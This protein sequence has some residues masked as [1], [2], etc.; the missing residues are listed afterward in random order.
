MAGVLPG[1]GSVQASKLDWAV[2]DKSK[3]PVGDD[4]LKSDRS[5]NLWAWLGSCSCRQW[6]RAGLLHA[7][8]RSPGRCGVG[9]PGLDCF[10]GP[11]IILVH[12][13]AHLLA[14]GRCCQRTARG[15]GHSGTCQTRAKPSNR[16]CERLPR[17]E[18]LDLARK[19]C[20]M[21]LLHRS[22]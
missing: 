17:L 18:L 6:S 5:G 22:P 12:G 19:A 20:S 9:G 11:R 2:I 15:Q 21:L 8:L 4:A 1:G 10:S 16:Q 14:S 13:A 7:V 3:S